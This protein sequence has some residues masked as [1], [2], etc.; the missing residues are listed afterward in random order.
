MKKKSLIGLITELFTSTACKQVRDVKL[1]NPN[2]NS[3]EIRTHNHLARKWTLNHFSQTACFRVNLNSIDIQATTE[4][5]F[6]LKH[7][8]DMRVVGS[9]PVAVTSLKLQIPCL[10]QARS[11]LTFRELWIHSETRTWHDKNIHPNTTFVLLRLF[12][13]PWSF[14]NRLG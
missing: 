9:N 13:L 12:F 10:L 6:F 2:H 5:R 14:P 11:S 4:C 7:V 3:N 1:L 8:C